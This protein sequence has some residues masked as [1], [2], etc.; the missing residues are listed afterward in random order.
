MDEAYEYFTGNIKTYNDE[1]LHL[2]LG[3][4]LRLRAGKKR[5]VNHGRAG[6]PVI[7]RSAVTGC[8]H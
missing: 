5:S 4:S 7:K 8:K 1:C 2:K 3:K 6:G